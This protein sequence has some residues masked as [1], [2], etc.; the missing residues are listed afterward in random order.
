MEPDLSRNAESN[1][2]HHPSHLSFFPANVFIAKSSILQNVLA[3]ATA[4]H[5]RRT[6]KNSPVIFPYSL[7]IHSCTVLFAET[8]GDFSGKISQNIDF[9]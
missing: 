7:V 8:A 1:W 3:N 2:S 9:C 4:S 6:E 5:H